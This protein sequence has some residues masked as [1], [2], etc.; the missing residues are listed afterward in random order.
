MNSVVEP[1]NAVLSIYELM[2]FTDVCFL[3]D[4]EAIYDIGQKSLQIE[5][6]NFRDINQ[7]IAQN[8][9]SFTSSLRFDGKWKIYQSL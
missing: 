2:E 1:Y 7:L 9:S 3:M 8:V 5:Q 6:P 4:N